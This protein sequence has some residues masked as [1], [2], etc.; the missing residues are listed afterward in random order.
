[1]AE[2]GA[3]TGGAQQRQ[4]ASPAA[5]PRAPGDAVPPG[6]PGPDD[7][8]G[9]EGAAA[10]DPGDAVPPGVAPL[11]P[12]EP[13]EEDLRVLEELRDMPRRQG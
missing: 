8:R 5:T 12:P 1:M 13:T 3:H 4:E 6:V 7:G 2:R 10:R 9:A 11:E